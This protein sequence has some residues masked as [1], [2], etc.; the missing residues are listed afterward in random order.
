MTFFFVSIGI[1][2]LVLVLLIVLL[3]VFLR[4]NYKRKTRYAVSYFIPVIIAIVCMFYIYTNLLPVYS[5][6]VNV[7]NRNYISS[8]GKVEEISNYNVCITID[9]ER[10]YINPNENNYSEGDKVKI[11]YTPTSKFIISISPEK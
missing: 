6:V 10:Y 4:R 3:L 11:K 8:T 7:F 9:G 1:L 5:D 2:S